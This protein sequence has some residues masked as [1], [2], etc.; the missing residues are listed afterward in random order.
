V[1]PAKIVVTP[2]LDTAART[3]RLPLPLR[4]GEGRHK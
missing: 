4:T 3:R 2:S 1:T